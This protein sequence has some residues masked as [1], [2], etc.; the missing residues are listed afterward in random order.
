VAAKNEKMPAATTQLL[1]EDGGAN[2][3]E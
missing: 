3:G 2:G 1:P